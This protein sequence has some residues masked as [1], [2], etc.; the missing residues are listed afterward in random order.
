MRK[1][2]F[3]IIV[4]FISI[5]GCNKQQSV[6]VVGPPLVI[7]GQNVLGIEWV[8][9]SCLMSCYEKNL[10]EYQWPITEDKITI[11]MGSDDGW[12]ASKHGVYLFKSTAPKGSDWSDQSPT[13]IY[14]LIPPREIKSHSVVYYW[15]DLNVKKGENSSQRE[16][17]HLILTPNLGVVYMLT[18]GDKMK[19]ENK[20]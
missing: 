18:S 5:A 6:T 7:D 8:E 12:D 10:P 9:E 14:K 19:S 15:S 2:V 11:A 1:V 17:R 3:V 16:G 20:F 13:I 4:V